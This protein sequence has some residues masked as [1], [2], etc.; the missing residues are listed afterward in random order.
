MIP[1]RPDKPFF[2]MNGDILTRA[3]FS[4]ILDAHNENGAAATMVVR[5]HYVDIP[6]G[7]V[8][9]NGDEILSIDEK[10]REFSFVNAGIYILSPRALDYIPNGE[11]F[12]MP[13]LFT[14]LKKSEENIRCFKL[15]DY[16]VDI[17]RLEDFHKAQA[18]FQGYFGE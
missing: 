14:R 12:D 9:V 18:E 11:F 1:E 16:W 3:K 13:S 5:E 17:G 2:V 15:K 10:P 7:V 6:Y 4:D 8:R